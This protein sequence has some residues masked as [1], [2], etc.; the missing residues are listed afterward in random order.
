VDFGLM[1]I[2]TLLFRA[3]VTLATVL[4]A[5]V[6]GLGLWD[7]YMEAPWTR[8]GKVQADVV[9]ITPDVS[10]LV[11]EILVVDN[12]QVKQGDVLFRV[13]PERYELALKQAIAAVEGK[14]AAAEQA[15][16]DYMRYSKL[17]ADATSEQK[18]ELARSTHLQAKADFDKAIAD[19]DLAQLNLDRSNVRA[20]VNGRVTNLNLRPGAYVTVGTGVMALIDTDTLR[21]EGYFEENKLPN[22]HVGNRATIRLMGETKDLTGHVDSIAGGIEDRD[23]S[24]GSNLL[25]NVNPTFA[26]V[27]LAQRIPVRIKLNT[28][29]EDVRLI[30]GRTATVS[31]ISEPPAKP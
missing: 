4:L 5:V 2:P 23:R 31:V 27:R 24:R 21:V 25:A 29:P 28:I 20:L 30:V 8:D 26:W 12:Q 18:V 3:A 7:Y 19:R 14:K 10:G 17:S 16:A 15:A 13:D 11:R 22:I 1:Q 6:I 9:A